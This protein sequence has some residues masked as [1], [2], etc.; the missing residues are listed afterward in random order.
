MR[1]CSHNKHAKIDTY[2]RNV[3]P[4]IQDNWKFNYNI[5]MQSACQNIYVDTYICNVCPYIEDNWR[6]NYII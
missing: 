5:N 4:Y 1:V 6:F 2:V 3:C